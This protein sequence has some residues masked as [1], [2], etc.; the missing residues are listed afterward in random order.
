MFIHFNFIE[1]R[2]F[3]VDQTIN[4]LKD[5]PEIGISSF[6][7]NFRKHKSHHQNEGKHQISCAAAEQR[8]VSTISFYFFFLT[9][10]NN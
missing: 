4:C 10:F 9:S 8:T 6:L 7:F 1:T 3:H 2:S 5:K